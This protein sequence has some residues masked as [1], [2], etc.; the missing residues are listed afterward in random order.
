MV[1]GTENAATWKH[2]LRNS[3]NYEPKTKISGTVRVPGSH[4]HM[5]EMER[6]LTKLEV[7]KKEVRRRFKPL[8]GRRIN[9]TPTADNESEATSGV[10]Y[11]ISCT[12]QLRSQYYLL[13]Q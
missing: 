6:W 10:H 8:E 4:M 9:Q 7:P 3:N 2:S 5:V 12:C 11:L 13:V 1:P